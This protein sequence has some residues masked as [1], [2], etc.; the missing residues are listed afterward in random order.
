MKLKEKQLFIILMS[1]YPVGYRINS[2]NAT[3]FRIWA[4]Q[5]LRELII[6]GFVLDDELLKK[7]FKIWN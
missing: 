5:Q 2:K 7:W 3:R 4:T 6:K 1:L